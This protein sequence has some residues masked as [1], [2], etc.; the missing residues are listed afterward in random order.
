[1]FPFDF[2]RK[3]AQLHPDRKAAEEGDAS[4]DFKRLIAHSEALGAAYQDISGKKRPIVGVLGPNGLQH[5]KAIMATHAALAT[6]VPLNYRNTPSDTS[7]LIDTAQPDLLFVDAEYLPKV[8]GYAGPIFTDRPDLGI[9]TIDQLIEEYSGQKPD[10]SGVSIGDRS[11]I[12]FTGGSTGKPKGL[13]QSF[14]CINSLIINMLMSFRFDSEDIH[15][16]VAPISHGAGTFMLPVLAA[17]GCNRLI[18]SAKP[19]ELLGELDEGGATTVFLPPTVIY[20]IIEA[21]EGR[22]PDFGHLRHVIFGAAPMPENKVREAREFFR[23]KLETVYGQTEMPTVMTVLRAEEMADP[24]LVASVGRATPLVRLAIMDPQ[25]R[26]LPAGEIGE[27]VAT[28]DMMMDGYFNLPDK[29]AETIID[30]WLHTG[31]VGMLDERGYLFL[32]DRI[33][34]VV[35]TGGFNV[36]PIDVEAALVKHPAVYEC[37]VFGVPDEKWGERVEA[38]VE[39]RDPDITPEELMAFLKEKIGSVKTPK[40]IHQVAELPRSNVGKVQR[41]ESREM[42]GGGTA[43]S[44][45]AAP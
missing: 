3:T 32:K 10:M 31:D 23:D 44:T 43:F 8:E 30:G 7:D 26:I 17:G 22:Q 19:H 40:V 21:A 1:M 6:L 24:S 34:D 4:I 9:P 37:V 20:S 28:G 38:A 29:T 14:R 36:Y 35:I 25:N 42:F 5:F 41:K 13:V 15:L 2:V 16:C 11:A 18:R 45:K 27:V 12:K 33:R 39:M